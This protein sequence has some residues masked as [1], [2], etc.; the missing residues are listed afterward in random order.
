MPLPRPEPGLVI[1]FEHL[2]SREAAAGLQD[3][4]K[5]RPCMILAVAEVPG[6]R[7]PDGSSALD[8]VVVPI[9]HARPRA[10]DPVVPL[11]EKLRAH[12]GLD[13]REQWIYAAEINVFRWPGRYIHPLPRTRDRYAYGMVTEKVFNTVRDLAMRAKPVHRPDD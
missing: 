1:R 11:S 12:L 8:V 4:E 7:G 3:A 5:P 2:W 13:G 10:G 9:S 6:T